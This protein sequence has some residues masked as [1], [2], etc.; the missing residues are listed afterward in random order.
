[1]T[2]KELLTKYCLKIS[3]QKADILFKHSKE[4]LRTSLNIVKKHPELKINITKL[5]KMAMLHDIGICKLSNK[6]PYI[7]HGII[8]RKILEN[9]GLKNIAK[10]CERH[11]GSGITAKEAKELGLPTRDMTPKTLEEKIVCYA[12][13]FYSK[14]KKG[15][16]T[17]TQIREE[18]SAY[19]KNSLKRF[20]K[21]H[22]MFS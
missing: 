7:K 13:K 12:D 17:I 4:V 22:R 5:E 10:I 1:M 16:H 9:E 3:V 6:T 19:G 15:R 21:L 14:S 20:E 2:T 11:I 18:F 8:G